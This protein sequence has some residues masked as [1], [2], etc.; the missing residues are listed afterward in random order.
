MISADE[1]VWRKRSGDLTLH[2]T[3]RN[4]AVLRVV[5][6]KTYT[7]MWRV[8]FPDGAVSDMANV[9]RAKDAAIGHALATVNRPKTIPRDGPTA[10]PMRASEFSDHG[11]TAASTL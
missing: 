6:D 8:E 3:N 10:P 4:A 11:I 2:V 7:G 1:L 5:P 9:T